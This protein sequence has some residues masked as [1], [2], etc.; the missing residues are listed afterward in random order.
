MQRMTSFDLSRGFT[1]F[2]M[3]AAHTLM[4][5]GNPVVHQ[6]LL[7]D[8]FRFLAEG[9]G[10]QLF[11]LLMGVSFTF[12]KR[13]SKEYIFQRV[14]ILL[15]AGYLLNF[16][17]FVVPLGLGLLPEN[18][19]AEFQLT[20]DFAAIHFFLFMGDI[21]HFA[22]IAYLILFLVSRS[23]HYALWSFTIAIAIMILS[24]LLWDVKPGI[25]FVDS[26]IL[27]FNGH[28]PETFFP[29]FPWIVYPLMG[30]T[31]GYLL[32]HNNPDYLLR[33]TG[34][35]GFGL[36]IISCVFPP[37]KT[38]VEWPSFYRTEPA[39]TLFHLGFV[40]LWLALFHRLSKKIKANPVFSLLIFCSKHIT[41]IYIIQWIL[42]CWC[43][44]ITGYMQMNLIH[45]IFWM[46]GITIAT[47]LLTYA[48]NN[49]P[50]KSI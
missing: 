40:L 22:A 46:A 44:V 14:F 24:P 42:I 10:A 17:K 35:T 39:D 49:A 16:F 2:I 20:S 37:T 38:V 12:S 4:M 11:M 50:R 45:T 26:I 5:Y 13:I 41:T 32:K 9:P 47:L 29:V 7:A 6:S 33:K 1:V 25:V 43:M 23:R 34:I 8:I 31:L 15:V 30:M 28:P 19:L 27:L 3:P 18:L 48:L 21:L 36:I